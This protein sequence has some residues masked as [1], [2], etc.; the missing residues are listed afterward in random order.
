MSFYNPKRH[1]G[2]PQALS[3]IQKAKLGENVEFGKG[4]KGK[5]LVKLLK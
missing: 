3:R 2:N 5:A 4:H 1:S